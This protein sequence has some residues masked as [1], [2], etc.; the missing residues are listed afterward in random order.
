MLSV[1][2]CLHPANGCVTGCCP[3]DVILAA[4]RGAEISSSKDVAAAE[5]T[6]CCNVTAVRLPGNTAARHDS[7]PGRTE[8]L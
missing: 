6:G 1:Y 8:L 3:F 2:I 5:W 7:P 4:E